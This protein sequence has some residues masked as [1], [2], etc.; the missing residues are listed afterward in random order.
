LRGEK[1]THEEE[2]SEVLIKRKTKRVRPTETEKGEEDKKGASRQI[3]LYK[4][5]DE[6]NYQWGV[7]ES[8]TENGFKL[9][10]ALSIEKKDVKKSLSLNFQKAIAGYIEGEKEF[11]PSRF[12]T[13]HTVKLVSTIRC[14][15]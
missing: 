13:T 15:H 1:A 3:L 5:E 10:N 6:D 9:T 12:L 2:M 4:R 11:R 7:V 8:E 14:T